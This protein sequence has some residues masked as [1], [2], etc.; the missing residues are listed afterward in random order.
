[1]AADLSHLLSVD[2]VTEHFLLVMSSL[3][4]KKRRNLSFYFDDVTKKKKKK[5]KQLIKGS[6]IRVRDKKNATFY[7]GDYFRL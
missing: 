5:R 2:V 1:M 6:R 3:L 4:T 7:I